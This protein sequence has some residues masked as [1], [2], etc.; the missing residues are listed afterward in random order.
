MNGILLALYLFSRRS[1][2]L[3]NTL[4]GALLLAIGFRTA[5]STFYY[6]NPDLAPVFL[7]LGLSACLLIGPLTYLYVHCYL[8]DLAQRPPDKYWHGHLLVGCLLI[9]MGVVF[10]YIDH[11]S[12]RYYVICGIHAYWFLYL[13]L[14]GKQLWMSRA[15]LAAEDRRRSLL[16]LSVYFGSFL[17]LLAYVSTPFTSYIVGALSFTFSIHITILSYLLQ[18]EV[19][20]DPEKK[21]KYQNRKLAQ[22]DAIALLES[23]NKMM[24]EQQLYLNP[25]LSL[26][27]LA[28]KMGSL[29]TTISQVIN[30]NSGKSF[31]AYIN[32][33]RI[34]YAKDLLVQESHLNME[35]VAERSGFNSDSTFFAAFKKITGQ[36]PASYRA[37]FAAKPTSPP[38]AQDC[39]VSI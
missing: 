14:A 25:M 28:K 17:I 23:L 21:E 13:L 18:N 10:P 11:A 24:H 15:L 16:L 4:L 5:K 34:E 1:H 6:F 36:T 12:T 32:E 39:Q 35:L 22:K 20:A 9:T 7:Q 38:A 19:V 30:E 26:A 8:A 29:Q 33:F 37:A 31:N 3:A 2:R 27:M